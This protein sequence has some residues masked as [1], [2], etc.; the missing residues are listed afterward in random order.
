M[1]PNNCRPCPSCKRE[2]REVCFHPKPHQFTWF[3]TESILLEEITVTCPNCCGHKTH[4]VRDNA[5][6]HTLR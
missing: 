4:N 1:E 6:V 5:D 3:L 2:T